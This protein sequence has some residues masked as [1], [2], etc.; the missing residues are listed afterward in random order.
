VQESDWINCD[1]GCQHL[2][3]LQVVQR[4]EGS[5]ERPNRG[6]AACFEIAQCLFGNTGLLSSCALIDVAREAQPTH[7]L[8]E[9][10]LQFA[11]GFED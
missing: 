1:L 4:L 11:L 10:N 5:E 6:P 8:A 3:A 7:T 2:D 9:S